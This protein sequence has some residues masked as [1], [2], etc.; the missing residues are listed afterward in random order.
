M[1]QTQKHAL[2]LLH[3]REDERRR[4]AKALHKGVAQTLAGLRIQLDWCESQ[5]ADNAQH[6]SQSLSTLRPLIEQSLTELQE[7]IAR[8]GSALPEDMGLPTALQALV[9]FAC[10]RTGKDIHF[11]IDEP[12]PALL[13]PIESTLYRTIKD[14]LSLAAEPSV[15]LTP[16]SL[17]LERHPAVLQLQIRGWKRGVRDLGESVVFSRIQEQAEAIGGTCV[18]L[19]GEDKDLP[20]AIV[21]TLPLLLRDAEETT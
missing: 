18:V 2:E 7:L 9:S 16:L 5:L 4:I 12:F 10:T 21:M 17:R 14:I 19:S 8:L 3:A 15:V 1:N 6:A 20:A 11:H 13:W